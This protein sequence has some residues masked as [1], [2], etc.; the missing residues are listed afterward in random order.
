MVFYVLGVH[1]WAQDRA[2]GSVSHTSTSYSATV[3]VH[4][5]LASD[6]SKYRCTAN[7]VSADTTSAL[8]VTGTYLQGGSK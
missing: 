6:S 1:V 5:A 7:G 4:Y 2:N 3:S 8:D